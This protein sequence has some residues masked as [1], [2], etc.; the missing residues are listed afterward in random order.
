[1]LLKVGTTLTIE[2]TFTETTE[3]FRCKVVEIE[4]GM[5][6]FYIDYPTNIETNKTAFFLDGVQLHVSFTEKTNA[7]YAFE[8][9]VL[10]RI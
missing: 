5:D 9:E 1:M 2:P 10:G 6:Y 8:T 7:A 3:R 4:E